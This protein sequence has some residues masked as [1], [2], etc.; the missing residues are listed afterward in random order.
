MLTTYQ[1]HH[2][3]HTGYLVLPTRL[4]A[5]RV[6]RLRVAINRD[7]DAGVEPLV[8]KSGRV[9][10]LSS[11]LDRDPV[12][13]DTARSDAVLDPLRDLLGPNIEVL[14]NRH[15]HATLNPRS[16]ADDFHRD[17]LQ[18]SRGLLTVIFYLEDTTVENGCT[19]L[20]PGSHLLPGVGHHHKLSE[21]D[22]I[23][24]SGLFDQVV[25]VQAAAGQ[26]LA[27]D[28]TIFHRIG[29]NRT[30]RTRMSMTVGYQS[31]DEFIDQDNPKRILVA[32]ERIY[33]GNDRRL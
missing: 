12:F 25:H 19:Q 32:G 27:I 1:V 20:I 18:W 30:D 7:V 15:N 22:W 13:L 5:D 26:M 9:V 33:G 23:A 4:T 10:R 11:L 24:T 8:R 31:V 3:R 17:N 28:S 21:V 6:E 29:D 2:F 16:P 14:K